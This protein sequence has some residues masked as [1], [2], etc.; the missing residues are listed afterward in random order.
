MYGKIIKFVGS[1]DPFCPLV[2]PPQELG[3][4][5]EEMAKKSTF[6]HCSNFNKNKDS[7]SK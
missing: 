6:D 3:T 7:N 5:L 4:I 1:L 2:N